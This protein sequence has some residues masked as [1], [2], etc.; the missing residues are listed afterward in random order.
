MCALCPLPLFL[1]VDDLFCIHADYVTRSVSSSEL[2][3]KLN[4]KKFARRSLV[5]EV[6]YCCHCCCVDFY[7]RFQQNYPDHQAQS[8]S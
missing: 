7:F 3:L 8:V 2:K 1:A 6:A 5:V 4:K